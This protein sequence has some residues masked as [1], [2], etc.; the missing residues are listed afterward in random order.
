MHIPAR[1]SRQLGQ[2][3]KLFWSLFIIWTLFTGG[4]SWFLAIKNSPKTN[5]TQVTTQNCNNSPLGKQDEKNDTPICRIEDIASNEGKW[6]TRFYSKDNEGFWCLRKG[7]EDQVM[8]YTEGILPAF[9]KISVEYE[10]IDS[11]KTKIGNPPSFIFAFGNNTP[12][13]KV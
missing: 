7:W 3:P 6:N 12:V 2:K 4:S 9:K 8:W 1:I 11:L 13:F 10:I 5:C